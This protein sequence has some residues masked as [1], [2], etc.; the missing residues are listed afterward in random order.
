MKQ[1]LVVAVLA[2]LLVLLFSGCA[3]DE[4]AVPDAAQPNTE[5]VSLTLFQQF[6]QF[7]DEEFQKLVVEPVKKKFPNLNVNLVL[8]E[9]NK[10]IEQYVT[11]GHFGDILMSNSNNLVTY[12]DLGLAVNLNDFIKK[13]NLDLPKFEPS[14][15]EAIQSYG[16]KGETYAIPFGLKRSAIF[17]NKDIFDKFAVPYPTD[18]MSW[19]DTI[20]LGK[21]VARTQDNISYKAIN[22]TNII[23]F[24]STLSLPY[25]DLQTNEPKLTSDG[26]K[27]AFEMFKRISD[28]PGNSDMRQGEIAF[29]KDRNLAMK[30]GFVGGFGPFEEMHERGNDLNWDLAAFPYHKENPGVGKGLNITTMMIAP[31]SK[32]PDEAFK[33]IQLMTS[34]EVQLSAS[35]SG[36]FSAL[37]DDKINSEFGKDVK[38][39]KGKNVAAIF[40][41]KPASLPPS[42]RYEGGMEKII[43]NAANQVVAGNT[44]V[45]SA[46]RN[47]EQEAKKFISAQ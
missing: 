47:A 23:H 9:K 27:K 46:L 19:D 31:T 42:T 25:L 40:K 36:R 30:I 43:Q 11:G 22:V 35:R 6:D 37:N 10:P 5:P 13:Y 7:S 45:N 28:I 41:S 38:V 15:V 21:K 20:E 16:K 26:W 2:S 3:K 14:A 4:S 39:L 12:L 18:N 29:Q 1:G 32:H 8:Q 44:D 33:V 24:A 34:G 17:Y